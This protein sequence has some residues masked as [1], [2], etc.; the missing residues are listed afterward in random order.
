[1]RFERASFYDA[2]FPSDDL[3]Q[4]DGSVDDRR[5]P[6]SSRSGHCRHRRPDEAARGRLV[7]RLRRGGRR[8][9]LARRARR[10]RSTCPTWPTSVT[11][12]ASVFLMGVT[13]G[14]PDF[15]QRYPV[16][17]RFDQDGGPFG[18]P[19]M[20]TLLP[21]QGTPLRPKTTYAAVITSATG[22]E[23][24]DEMASIASGI[25]PPA[26]TEAIFDEYWAAIG[27]LGQAG[28]SASDIAGLCRLHDGRSDDR[29][30]PRPGRH[31]FATGPGARQRL[32]PDRPVRRHTASTRRRSPCRTTRPGT[33]PTR[34]TT[35][36]RRLAVRRAPASRCSSERRKPGMV[37]TIPRAPMP[38]VGLAHRALHPHRRRRQSAARRPRARRR[39]TAGPPSRPGTGPA[40][41]F[42]MAGL[43]GASVDG[44]HEDLRNLTNDNEDFLMFNINNADALRDNIRESAAEYALF[45]HMLAGL[46]LDVSDCPGTTSPATFDATR[47]ALMGHSMGST[48]A[49]LVLAAEPMY[50][51]VVLSGAGASWIE[52]I[53]WKQ[54]P[55]AIRPVV[56][57]LLRYN[58][59]RSAPRRAGGRPG[60][61][62]PPVVGRARRPARLHAGAPAGAGARPDA[63]PGAHGAGDRRSLH[64]AAHRQR[65]EPVARPRPRAVRPSTR[66]ARSSSATA[67]RRSRACSPY[68][69]R[70]QLI[71]AGRRQPAQPD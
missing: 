16:T 53:I 49:P 14:S 11:P 67:R 36:R 59:A 21:L 52:N 18:A 39:P 29:T 68:S 56:D 8:L 61:H 9:L 15:L 55:L 28:I 32:P 45:A 42:A 24:S 37:V 20:L 47:M 71:A 64:H 54:L 10:S 34:S 31:A 63:A 12:Q 23:A 57:L 26:M 5:L 58:A 46:T 66:R 17:V 70:R 62:A 51:A 60:P 38:A 13:P 43:A 2:P 22:L 30:R 33:L 25:R 48:I 4:P 35:T 40:L 27:S 44:P 3:I 6:E 19:D 50:R 1:M 65:D 69:G 7:A 41:W